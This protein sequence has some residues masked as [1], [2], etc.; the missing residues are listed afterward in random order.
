MKPVAEKSQELIK[1]HPKIVPKLLVK[2]T[3]SLMGRKNSVFEDV[4]IFTSDIL[5]E[6][7]LRVHAIIKDNKE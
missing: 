7:L 5:I 1:E 2:S 3:S 4:Q 6:Y